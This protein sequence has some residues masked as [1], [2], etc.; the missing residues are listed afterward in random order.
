MSQKSATFRLAVSELL[1][2]EPQAYFGMRDVDPRTELGKKN[3]EARPHLQ[4]TS[5]ESANVRL[6]PTWFPGVWNEDHGRDAVRCCRARP[7]AEIL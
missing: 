7:L 4:V 3:P 6:L 5:N 1:D 2:E